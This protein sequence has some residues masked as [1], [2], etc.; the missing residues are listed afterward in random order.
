[1]KYIGWILPAE[2]VNLQFS[3]TYLLS[4]QPNRRKLIIE[5]VRPII[6]EQLRSRLVRVTIHNNMR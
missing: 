4:N 2:I 1:M 3:L 6:K 5:D